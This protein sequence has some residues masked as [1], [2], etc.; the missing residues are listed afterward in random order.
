M[1]K[2]IFVLYTSAMFLS[3]AQGSPSDTDEL[4]RDSILGKWL[5]GHSSSVSVAIFKKNGDYQGVYYETSKM[6]KKLFTGYGK[7]WIKKGKLYNQMNKVIPPV[8]PIDKDKIYIDIIVD[9]SIDTLTMIDEEGKQYIMQ[10][11]R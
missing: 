1:K 4:L 11:I 9:I 6:K 8:I 3:G 2:I 7:W 5:E 10:R